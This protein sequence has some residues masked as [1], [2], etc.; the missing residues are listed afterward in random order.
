MLPGCPCGCV[1]PPAGC[2][3]SNKMGCTFPSTATVPDTSNVADRGCTWT[4]QVQGYYPM[5]CLAVNVC[6]L[7]ARVLHDISGSPRLCRVALFRPSAYHPS[8]VA[9]SS[10]VDRAAAEL[11]DPS[12]CVG[13]K[14]R[15][16][17]SK[18]GRTRMP[19]S[20]PTHYWSG[21]VTVLADPP[22]RPSIHIAMR[23]QSQAELET[24]HFDDLSAGIL[25]GALFA[26]VPT[27]PD[28]SDQLRCSFSHSAQRRTSVRE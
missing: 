18:G 25:L 9:C 10:I 26:S 11:L 28:K 16:S 5:L 20:R 6:T 2:T 8:S 1:S 17:Q 23:R 3:V 24:T 14:G 19:V 27:H 12:K 15:A 4:P 7:S 22:R 13:S 21:V